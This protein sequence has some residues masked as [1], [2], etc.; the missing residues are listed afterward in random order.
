ML[1]PIFRAAAMAALALPT[2]T[3]AQSE[4]APQQHW[5]IITTSRIKP[6]FRAE[7]EAVQKEVTAAYKKANMPY[8]VVVQTM[9][10]DLAEYTSVAPLSKY[11]DLDGAGPVEQA[12]GKAPALALLK[13]GGGYITHIH[14]EATRSLPDV[15][16]DTPME[17]PGEYAIV[18][19]L[20]L[21]P[22][23]AQDWVSFMKD[24]YLP[25][26]RKADVANL[27]VSVPAFGADSNQRIMVRMM[28]KMAEIDAG[29]A[30]RKALGEE[31]ARKLGMKASGIVASS[32]MD[33]VR[34]RA[35]LSLMP[36]PPKAKPGD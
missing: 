1:P 15:S 8:R 24:D 33:I 28:R 27:W 14:R 18:T 30:V 34:I 21:M 31:G 10:G 7:Y 35:D 23:K 6:E 3:F 17:N 13:R 32:H 12:L 36:A 2:F 20:R 9:F 26:M 5:S 22:G 16:I 25:A 19:V 29:P 11:A 4:S